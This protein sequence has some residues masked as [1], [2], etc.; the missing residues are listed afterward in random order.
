M[1]SCKPPWSGNLKEKLRKHGLRSLCVPCA[2]LN[3]INYP[4]KPDSSPI[5][6]TKR[7]N[8]HCLLKRKRKTLLLMPSFLLIFYFSQ[9]SFF[10]SILRIL[11]FRAS[12]WTYDEKPKPTIHWIHSYR[13]YP[14]LNLSQCLLYPLNALA[15]NRCQTRCVSVGTWLLRCSQTRCPSMLR[16]WNLNWS[17]LYAHNR[18]NIPDT[19]M[20]EVQRSMIR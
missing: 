18:P 4:L 9:H 7:R 6:T 2:L 8:M 17:N 11:V 14:L 10:H 20:I 16:Q 1:G 15:L 5:W 13:H 12:S 3:Y 19:G